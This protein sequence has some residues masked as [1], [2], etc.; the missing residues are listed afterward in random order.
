V[1]LKTQAP[2]SL[3]GMLST[4]GHC[5]Q[6]GFAIGKSYVS[7]LSLRKASASRCGICSSSLNLG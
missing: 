4:S 1:P 7:R 3:S 5:D 6:S 2:L